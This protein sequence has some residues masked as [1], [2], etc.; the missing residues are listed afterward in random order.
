LWLTLDLQILDWL[1]RG[2][3]EFVHPEE[4]RVNPLFQVVL[5]MTNR[6]K[7]PLPGPT[8][9]YHCQ[10]WRT[11]IRTVWRNAT[12]MQRERERREDT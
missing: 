5:S 8:D 10:A 3:L 1:L 9:D 4:F 2:F 12:G 7:A 11:A 6:D